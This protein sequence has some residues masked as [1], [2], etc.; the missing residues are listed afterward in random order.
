M[1]L[2][3]QQTAN[4]VCLG[5]DGC[6]LVTSGLAGVCVL[7]SVCRED[8]YNKVGGATHPW[9]RVSQLVLYPTHSPGVGHE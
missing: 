2:T 8:V 1:Y 6:M 3:N 9:V 7:V 4:Y 5:V